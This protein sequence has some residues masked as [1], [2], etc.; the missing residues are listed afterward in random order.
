MSFHRKV[1]RFVL[2]FGVAYAATAS[3]FA[4]GIAR[5]ELLA[6][7]AKVDV[8]DRAAGPVGDP[9]FVKVLALKS[10]D[11]AAVVIT[12]D[13]VA[14][15]EIGRI[16][17][18]YL[19]DVRAELAKSP[20]IKPEQVFVNASHCHGVVKVDDIVKKTAAA[21]REAWTSLEPVRIGVG[22]G[23]EDRISENRRLKLKDGGES[24]V[25]RAYAV[26]ADTDLAAIGPV[27]PE[28]GLVRIDRAD[29][30]PLAVVYNF[31]CHPIM[32]VPGGGNTADFPGYASELIETALGDGALAIFVQGCAGDVNPVRYKDV[33]EPHDAAPLG[34]LL[35]LSVLK[36]RKQLSVTDA[37]D[38]R[39]ISERLALPWAGDYES[40]I[41]ALESKQ[42]VLLESL[43][44]TSLN[45]ETFLPLYVRYKLDDE[46]PL[47]FAH[48]YKRDEAAG[49]DD[50]KKLDAENRAAIDAYLR[51]IGVM[52]ELTRLRTN[53]ALLK[54]HQAQKIAAGSDTLDVEI[55]GLRLGDF[56]LVTFP[57]ELT[58]QVGL[59]IKNRAAH[60]TTFVAGYTN[61]YIY[62]TPTVE[63]RRNSGYAQEDCDS[64]VAPEWQA[65]FEERA[66]KVL[67][68][69]E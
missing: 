19:V 9:L 30:R 50:L 17:A 43:K 62:Y 67:K 3:S 28:I 49:R 7:V 57:G 52:E 69:L 61:G 5:A 65:I 66:A 1:A 45:F 27:D 32:G 56:R 37:A 34:H 31:A 42:A 55:G 12:V 53:L 46:T 4:H 14:I 33:H 64:L 44:G 47:S 60:D 38:L 59:N 11:A 13:A 51:N 63:Q 48:R 54:K 2:S 24:D 6:G 22:V 35:G 18:S 10:G 20:G 41:A 26:A 36:A 40:R 16:K 21:V 39:T 29:G 68:T 15:G 8:T 58:T 23:R 25:R